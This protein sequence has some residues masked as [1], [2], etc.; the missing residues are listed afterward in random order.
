MPVIKSKNILVENWL[1]IARDK[2]TPSV[3]FRT[4]I[5]NIGLL[6]FSEAITQAVS[7]N[8]KGL[9]LRQDIKTPLKRTQVNFIDQKHIYLIPI[10]RAGLGM[11]AG[12]KNLLPEAKVSHV[13]LYRNE[14]TLEP[15]WYLDKLPKKITKRS[16]FFIL[17]PMLA[18][19]GTISEVLRRIIILGSVKIHVIS[20]LTTEKTKKLLEERF[21]PVYFHVAAI[22]P[23]L[24]QKG[25]I[26]PGLGDAGDR[27]FN[28]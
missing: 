14:F 24:N 11:L 26:V 4:A 16:T 21:P 28:L 3:H 1:N 9:I 19:G 13:G 7:N 15:H 12:I 10:L 23:Q 6:L 25:Y 17:E 20:A 8:A 27:A 18:T 2:D 5:E 22:D